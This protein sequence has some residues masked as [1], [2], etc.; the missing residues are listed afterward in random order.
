MPLLRIVDAKLLDAVHKQ[1]S[2][3][4][5]IAYLKAKMAALLPFRKAADFLGELLPLSAQSTASTVRNRTMK[6]GKRLGKSAE[7]LATPASKDTC[8]ELIVGLAGTE[9]RFLTL[10]Y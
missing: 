9:G 4:A 7:A 2:H 3:H 10:S 5:R 1:E 6:V 8:K